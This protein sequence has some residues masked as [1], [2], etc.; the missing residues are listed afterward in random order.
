[1]LQQ[2]GGLE[3]NGSHRLRYLDASGSGTTWTIRRCGLVG[4][5]VSLG[6]GFEVSWALSPCQA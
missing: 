4:G 1:V 2:C 5:S 6:E 3:V